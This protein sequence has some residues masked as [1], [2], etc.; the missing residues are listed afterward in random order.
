MSVELSTPFEQYYET[1]QRVKN[2]N[3]PLQYLEK[4]LDYLLEKYETNL[5]EIYEG[6]LAIALNPEDLDIKM[7]LEEVRKIKEDFELYA[8]LFENNTTI[9]EYLEITINALGKLIDG[10]RKNEKK[11]YDEVNSTNPNFL[12]TTYYSLYLR[13]LTIVYAKLSK[14]N[15]QNDVKTKD[16]PFKNTLH[17]VNLIV[18]LLGMPILH[19]LKTKEVFPY[20]S[21]LSGVLLHTLTN[22]APIP[23]RDSL[24]YY[25][26]SRIHAKNE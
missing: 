15:I 12:L 18:G 1:L 9:R 8:S 5:F 26:F 20:I 7:L 14:L 3:F 22:E 2:R 16:S 6:I 19:Y 21:E 4:M 11:F 25:L 10:L 24:G 23:S 17:F 13:Y